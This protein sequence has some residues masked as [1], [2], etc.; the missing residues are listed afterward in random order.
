MIIQHKPRRRLSREAILPLVISALGTV[1]VVV[2]YY[3]VPGFQP[4]ELA[5]MLVVVGL[6]AVGHKQGIIRGVMTIVMLYVATGVAATFYRTIA[7]YVDVSVRVL[8]LL[9][10]A[11]I[12]TVTSSQSNAPG[13]AQAFGMEIDRDTL[14]ISFSLLTVIIWGALEAIGRTSFKD[15]SLPGLGILDSL[16]GVLVHLVIGILVAS[17]LFNAIGYGQQRRVHNQA[18][19][20]PTFN[21]ALYLYYTT[22]SFWFPRRPPPL[23]V[24]DLDVPH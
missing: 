24:Y 21:Q 6:G 15:T 22:Q 9:W 5:L 20:R 2:L 16:G 17:L 13:A 12:E 10:R 23:Y 7:P 19:L 1:G 14:A 4:I 11:V 8:A 18:L 3:L